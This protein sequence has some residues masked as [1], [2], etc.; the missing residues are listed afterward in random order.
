MR[1][2]LILILSLILLICAGSCNLYPL[3][4]KLLVEKYNFTINQ[5]NFFGTCINIGLWFSFPTGILY[6]KYGPRISFLIA[7]ICLPGSY[8]LLHYLLNINIDLEIPFVLFALMAIF[9][10]Q[11]SSICYT[12]AMTINVNNF[13]FKDSSLI[14][15]MIAVNISLGPSIFAFYK[16]NITSINNKN[17]YFLLSAFLAIIIFICLITFKRFDLEPESYNNDSLKSLA[18]YRANKIVK[19]IYRLNGLL[20]LCF[21]CSFFLN[22]FGIGISKNI[23]LFLFPLLI[24]FQFFFLYFSFNRY[25]NDQFETEYVTK[26]EDKLKDI[27]KEKNQENHSDWAAKDNVNIKDLELIQIPNIKDNDLQKAPIQDNLFSIQYESGKNIKKKLVDYE[28]D[29]YNKNSILI[30]MSE[31]MQNEKDISN[32]N[33]FKRNSENQI[34]QINEI[35]N[36]NYHKLYN[37]KYLTLMF[38][39][40]FFGMGSVI[41]NYNNM[42]FIVDTLYFMESNIEDHNAQKDFRYLEP[43]NSTNSTLFNTSTNK[44][45]YNISNL[46]ISHQVIDWNNMF[47]I[48][49]DKNEEIMNKTIPFTSFK[50]ISETATNVTDSELIKNHQVELIEIETKRL[51]KII[52]NKIFF[53]VIIY[54]TSNAITRLFSNSLL[55]FLIHK[56]CMFYHLLLTNALGLISQLL[57]IVMNKD[58]FIVIIALCGSCH[59]FFMT[60]IPIYVKKYYSPQN[61]GFILGILTSGAALGSLINSNFLFVYPYRRFGILPNEKSNFQVCREYECFFYSF[62][63]NSIFFSI[64]MFISLYLIIRNKKI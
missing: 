55:E 33:D 36:E 57:G 50:N 5:I 53:Y 44:I 21:L 34:S 28:N 42:S 56:D 51:L 62:I 30:Y 6:D 9:L 61:F 10:G 26:F 29:E 7:L 22:F 40:L 2:Y 19:N 17:F 43:S 49:H 47:N 45:I 18:K 20:C 27:K 64:N 52:K 24:S 16:E 31:S 8:M 25:H 54:F 59:G 63:L 46:N 35:Y 4:L 37:Y 12:T 23:I 39:S 15:S 60:F 58:L 1:K 41:S 48:S 32:N 11:G 13:K 3:Y 14:V 38:L